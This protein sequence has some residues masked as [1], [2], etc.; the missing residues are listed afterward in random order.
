MKNNDLLRLHLA[1]LKIQFGEHALLESIASLQGLSVADLE[2]LLVDID[3]VG[4][5]RIKKQSP[6]PNPRG[7]VESLL[8][9]HPEKADLIRS[10][11]KRFENRTILPEMKDVRRFLERHDS[12]AG[13][14][15]TRSQAFPRLVRVLV[16]LPVIE[17]ETI[18]NSQPSNEF[19]GLGIIADEILGRK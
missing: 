8:G 1:I 3:K 2:A 6:S 19:S 9:K 14:I 17:L 7:A 10:I 16:D 13:S 5:G 12:S 4:H 11:Q 15:K 18:L